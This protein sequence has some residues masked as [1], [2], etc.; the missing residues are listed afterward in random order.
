MAKVR[1]GELINFACQPASGSEYVIAGRRQA[2][3]DAKLEFCVHLMDITSDD[4]HNMQ[5]NPDY[6]P[7]PAVN[8]RLSSKF[9]I[10]I[11]MNIVY[12]LILSCRYRCTSWTFRRFYQIL[13][14]GTLLL[15]LLDRNR[16][17]IYLDRP[18]AMDMAIQRD[19]PIKSLNREKLGEDVLFAFDETK[20][21]LAVCASTKVILV[22]FAGIFYP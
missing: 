15:V 1:L 17:S 9:S 21:S 3:E 18:H 6:I 5:L 14:H 4:K 8:E 22:L 2:I 20:R 10:P 13:E 7:S 16:V 19:S 12:G 11:S